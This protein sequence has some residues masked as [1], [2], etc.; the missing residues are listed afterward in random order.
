[1][2]AQPDVKE[3]LRIAKE[4]K[5]VLDDML[6][7]KTAQERVDIKSTQP[8]KDKVKLLREA[9]TA[10]QELRT[11]QRDYL[12]TLIKQEGSAKKLTGIYTSIGALEQKRL[13]IQG[14]ALGMDKNKAAVFN[15][16][17]EL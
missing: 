10:V 15:K 11:K 16:I 5:A 1:M 17:A 7:N 3:L 6:A 2:A 8:Y 13:Q 4:H 9:N 12:D 14:R